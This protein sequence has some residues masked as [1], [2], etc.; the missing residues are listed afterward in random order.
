MRKN[1]KLK[2]MFVNLNRVFV[3]IYEQFFPFTA[4]F[5]KIVL[6]SG[7]VTVHLIQEE[8]SAAEQVSDPGI[9]IILAI[10]RPFT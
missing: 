4:D 10:D 9:R 3:P 5:L 8:E 2:E 6:S 7:S 1:C